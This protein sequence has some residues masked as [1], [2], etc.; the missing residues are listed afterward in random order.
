MKP[1]PISDLAVI[2]PI[3]PGESHWHNLANCL[4]LL[5]DE[6]EL[7]FVFSIPPGQSLGTSTIYSGLAGQ[8]RR[9]KVNRGDRLA[10]DDYLVLQRLGQKRTV[11]LSCS[12]GRANAMNE[13]SRMTQKS[14]LWFLHADCLFSVLAVSSLRSCLI[15][16]PAG[17]WFF[18]IK[19]MDDAGTKLV[20]LN[21]KAARIR[22]EKL[23]IPFGDQGFCLRRDL[24][25]NAGQYPLDIPMGEDHIFIWKIRQA[26]IPIKCTGADL[27]TSARKYKSVGWLKITLSY[28]YIWIR[29]AIPQ[30]ALLIRKKITA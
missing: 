30:F 16:D 24:F 28:Q 23:G 4:T 21:E 8:I 26:G 3:G 19:F 13:G 5:P 14:Y 17:L 25:F 22:S 18:R 20:K 10:D 29:Q 9:E 6:T 1:D 12:E 27:L 11:L 7:I 2:I 15:S